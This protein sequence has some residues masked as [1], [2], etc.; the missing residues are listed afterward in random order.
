MPA[1]EPRCVAA[2]ETVLDWLT[3]TSHRALVKTIDGL[4]RRCSSQE[5]NALA[6]CSRLG[7]LAAAA[8]VTPASLALLGADEA[9]AQS[10]VSRSPFRGGSCDVLVIG[11]GLAGSAAALVAARA[12]A[13]VILIDRSASGIGLPSSL[14]VRNVRGAYSSCSGR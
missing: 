9:L 3:G 7:G 4:V 2:A 6:V 8:V 1:G 14:R 5:G 10:S 11:A 13:R 12:G